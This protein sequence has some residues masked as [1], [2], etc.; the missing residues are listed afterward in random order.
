MLVPE[1][2]RSEGGN[3]NLRLLSIKQLP[4]HLKG[5]ILL[6]RNYLDIFCW[7]ISWV[8]HSRWT[9]TTWILDKKYLL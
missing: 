7:M 8:T 1:V 6:V 4:K 9:H 3:P 5:D 2:K